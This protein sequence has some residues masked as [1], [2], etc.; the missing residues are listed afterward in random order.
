MRLCQPSAQPTLTGNPRP[1]DALLMNSRVAVGCRA[2]GMGGDAL[3]AMEYFDAGCGVT[4]FELLAGELIR[5]AV[6][7]PVDLDVIID[8][9]PDRLPFGHHVALGWQRL[10]SGPVDAFKQRSSRAFAFAERPIIQALQQFLNR[11]IELGNREEL[12]MPERG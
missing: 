7:V 11:L 2:A 9:R 5:N 3:A 6:V 12:A 8:V 4:G 1:S 10:K